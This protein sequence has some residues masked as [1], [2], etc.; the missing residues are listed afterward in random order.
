[1]KALFTSFPSSDYPASKRFYEEAVGLRVLRDFDGGPQRFTNYDLDA[2][3]LKIY[4]W[5]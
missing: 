4:E 3:V 1:M 2:M 5:T